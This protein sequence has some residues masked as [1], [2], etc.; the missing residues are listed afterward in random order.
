VTLQQC[1]PAMILS[2]KASCGFICSKGSMWLLPKWTTS[3]QQGKTQLTKLDTVPEMN[4][5]MLDA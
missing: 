3:P 1:I 2:N 4:L 5:N